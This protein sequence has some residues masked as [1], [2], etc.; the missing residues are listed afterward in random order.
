MENLI[1]KGTTETPSVEF[2]NDGNLKL[3]GRA[4]PD[5][6]ITLFEPMRN[7]L[8]EFKTEKI[9]FDINLEYLNTSASMQL[10]AILR[11]LDSNENIKEIQVL[12]HYEEDDEDHLYTGEMYADRLDRTEFKYIEELI[13]A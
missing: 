3:S 4:I 1:I 5:N 10:F 12:W 2:H 9:V 13:A 6:A 8:K 11:N 7:W